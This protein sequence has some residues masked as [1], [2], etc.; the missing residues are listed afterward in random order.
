MS[1]SNTFLK[2]WGRVGERERTHA[3]SSTITPW[4]SLKLDLS[5][6][7]LNIGF[8]GK[9]VYFLLVNVDI[10]S[11]YLGLIWSLY[12][13]LFYASLFSLPKWLFFFI[14]K[15]TLLTLPPFPPKIFSWNGPSRSAQASSW[16]LSAKGF[17][18]LVKKTENSREFS[19]VCR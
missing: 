11:F 6:M 2:T 7:I 17:R 5:F 8:Y 14:C 13:F 9:T 15:I 10:F 12:L 16:S 19:V 4:G 1:A 3:F 18:S